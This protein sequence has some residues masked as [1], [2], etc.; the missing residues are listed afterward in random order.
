[1]QRL[2]PWISLLATMAAPASGQRY[3][4][5]PISGSP[6]NITALMQDS[7]SVL[8][9]GT[10]DDALAFDGQRFYS[11]HSAGFP[12]EHVRSFAE[13]REGG[14]WIATAQPDTTSSSPKGG[15]YRYWHGKVERMMARPAISLASA[16]QD[17]ILATVV[18]GRWYDMGDLY[19]F[20]NHSGAW[21]GT[22]ITEA[23]TTQLHVDLGGTVLF[24][25][26]MAWCEL[27]P[28]QIAQWSVRPLVPARHALLGRL[29][30]DQVY[31]DRF[32]CVWRRGDLRTSYQCPGE[33]EPGPIAAL[34][35]LVNG[36]IPLVEAPDGSVVMV[37]SGGLVFARS[38]DLV[39]KRPQGLRF[40]REINGVPANFTAVLPLRDGTLMLGTANGL[41]RMM[42][43][44]QLEY[45]N[46]QDGVDNPFSVLRVGDR[47]FASNNGIQ[48]L[49]SSRSKWVHWVDRS[50]IGHTTVNMIPGPGG[51]LYAASLEVG[52]TQLTM[53]G[54]VLARTRAGS[55]ADRIATDAQGKLWVAGTGVR[56]V[57][58]QGSALDFVSEGMDEGPDSF[59][60][61][62]YDKVSDT[63]W[64]CH[65]Q[66][67][68]F[69]SIGLW[70]TV[71]QHDGLLNAACYGSAVVPGG[72]V[73]VGYDTREE[74]S[75]IH[76]SAEGKLAV[77]TIPFQRKGKDAGYGF[78]RADAR[79]RLWN[80]D[81]GE[82]DVALPDAAAH[83]NWI[84]L[85]VDD[86]IPM[87]GGN[88]NS[89]FP[90][91]DGSVWFASGDTIVHFHPPDEFATTF[92]A[93]ELFVSSLSSGSNPPALPDVDTAIPHGESLVAHVGSLQFDRRG[94]LRLR[95]RLLP[96]QT[97]WKESQ[98]FDLALGKLMPGRYTLEVQ[99]RM[100]TGPWS[101][102]QA[103]TFRVLWPVLLTWP[104]LLLYLVSGSTLAFAANR[105]S[106][107]QRAR[108][109]L[110]LPD[111]LPWRNAA[112][113]PETEHL[114]GT[115]VDGRYEI[116]H[117][118]SVGGFATV[119][120]ARDLQ[121]DGQLCA[122]KIF[123]FELA[124]QEWIRHR[125]LHEVAALEQLDHP[126][127]VKITG[128]GTVDTGAPY[129]VMEFIQGR[130]LREMLEHGALPNATV[131]RFLRQIASA[132]AALHHAT[133]YHRDLK[134]E[135]LMIR[136]DEHGEE[137]FVLIDFSIAIVKSPDK[138]FHG[139]SR[140]AGTLGY[141]APEQVTGYAD[142]ST[143]IHSLAKVVLEMLTGKRCS[144]LFP[145]A[146][147]DLPDHVHEYFAKSA[148]VFSAASIGLIAAAVTFDP[149]RRPHDVQEFAEPLIRDL[150]AQA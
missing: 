146:T 121:H 85:G 37:I 129:L 16:V 135:N 140:V 18:V 147:L 116:G 34:N 82:D 125:F 41:F 45:W 9:V 104:L 12:Q 138:T 50:K 14:I 71:S 31:R 107:Y 96:S 113:S 24:P 84:R 30:L 148:G 137:Q 6:A 69:R 65:N 80:A 99:G 25:C 90:D 100:L 126:N 44:L 62:E 57:A 26:N 8:W 97:E 133:I 139:I 7:R 53:D 59:L 11:L 54:K 101:D 15:V 89:L 51:T 29:D 28:E 67:V 105:W 134:P 76:R 79:G 144:D 118:L 123:R 150:E 145:E 32:N 86:G 3:P 36:N 98:S 93:P 56:T 33:P 66:Q 77:D 128:H 119:A 35:E 91:G 20:G 43:P 68:V 111:L 48:T 49:D 127:I 143:D 63:L 120:R 136:Q 10:S 83:G 102:V 130:S 72:D 19:A 1:M 108:H 58:R 75:R 115:A 42:Y 112:Q 47:V 132:L 122:V 149:A 61:L 55:G 109:D 73:W 52:V 103:Q 22:R 64:A 94:S 70:N 87:P 106:K 40:V 5:L 74:F 110:P 114:I 39:A 88:Q 95:Y 92:S 81:E 78:L 124:D 23:D 27:P 2:A 131:A 4:I 141:M 142:A 17:T 60:N 46:K 13:D 21:H 38:P 117:I